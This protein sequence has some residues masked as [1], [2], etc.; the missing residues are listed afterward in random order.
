MGGVDII[1]SQ[2]RLLTSSGR[3][4]PRSLNID[5]VTSEL[6][7]PLHWVIHSSTWVLMIGKADQKLVCSFPESKYINL[8]LQTLCLFCER[9]T[10][11][12]IVLLGWKSRRDHK[13][14]EEVGYPF[15]L[16]VKMAI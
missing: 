2:K 9:F 8:P 3:F 13:I 15:S 7:I 1:G 12:N 10:D 4:V 11:V 6:F 14:P 16:L 5:N